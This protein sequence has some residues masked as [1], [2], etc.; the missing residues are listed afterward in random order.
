MVK[1]STPTVAMA[2]TACPVETGCVKEEA[3]LCGSLSN[4]VIWRNG[5]EAELTSYKMTQDFTCLVVPSCRGGLA[6][7]S[8]ETLTLV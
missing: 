3:V 1:E 2:W 4:S 5:T 8:R 6:V 7:R